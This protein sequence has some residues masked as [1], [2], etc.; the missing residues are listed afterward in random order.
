MDASVSGVISLQFVCD[1][2]C[3]THTEF[4][5]FLKENRTR[6]LIPQKIACTG[7]GVCIDCSDG[8]YADIQIIHH[9]TDGSDLFCQ[10]SAC[11]IHEDDFD[12][13]IKSLSKTQ[14]NRIDRI[15]DCKKVYTKAHEMIC[16]VGYIYTDNED[17][18]IDSVHNMTK[19]IYNLSNE[20]AQLKCSV[21]D[22]KNRLTISTKSLGLNNSKIQ[23]HEDTSLRWKKYAQ[24]I[25]EY[26]IERHKNGVAK[27]TVQD[28]SIWIEHWK[29]FCAKDSIKN[30]PE[31]PPEMAFRAM[32]NALPAELK[33]S[34][35]NDKYTPKLG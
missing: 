4:Y 35:P 16:D 18:F 3:M 6:I 30:L 7:E 33:L 9:N 27:S 23:R 5:N 31:K 25:A 12:N 28:K 14:I 32:R 26:V 1:R 15:Y 29:R 17:E 22:L 34:D 21:E 2:L 24:F 20:N 11:F 19:K 13:I 8:S 10:Y